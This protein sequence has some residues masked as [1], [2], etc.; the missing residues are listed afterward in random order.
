MI[1]ECPYCESKVDGE[2]KGEHESYDPRED[3]GPFKAVLLKCPVCNNALLGGSDLEQTGPT[4][5]GWSSL[6]RLW[7]QQESHIPWEIPAIVRKSLVEARTCFKARA[8]SACAVM[9]GRT[10]EGVCRHHS[11]NSNSLAHGLKKLQDTGIIDDR[12]YQWGE[13]LRKHRNIGAHATEENI[14]KDDAK[15]LLDFALAIC[16][17]VFVLNARFNRFMER[18]IKD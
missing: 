18:K 16:D 8:Y 15:D 2:V 7:P 13:E 10:L 1:I 11:T 17:Y 3:P 4:S 5:H 6:T 9:S 14:S 12:L